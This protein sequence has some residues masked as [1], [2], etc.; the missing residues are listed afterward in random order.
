MCRIGEFNQ[1][2]MWARRQSLNDQG[3]AACI[4]PMPTGII[5]CDV[6]MTDPRHYAECSR[7]VDRNDTEVVGAV[8][9]DRQAAR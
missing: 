8:L 9:N 7:T 3:F 4:H 6:D 1:N 2:A 5:E